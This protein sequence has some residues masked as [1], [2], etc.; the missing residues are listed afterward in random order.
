M[1]GS[2]SGPYV[3]QFWIHQVLLSVV[4]VI[5][6]THWAYGVGQGFYLTLSMSVLSGL[7]GSNFIIDSCFHCRSFT[8]NRVHSY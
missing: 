5:L 1:H 4:I 3:L 2:R 7:M 6:C 8:Y